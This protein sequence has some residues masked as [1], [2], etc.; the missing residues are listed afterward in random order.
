MYDSL[1]FGLWATVG[2]SG[3]LYVMKV[4]EHAIEK[5]LTEVSAHLR[6][7]DYISG[8]VGRF[9]SAQPHITQYVIA[10]QEDLS[11]EGVVTTL[12][13]AAV[14]RRSLIEATGRGPS[15][16]DY[17]ALDRAAKAVASLEALAEEEP[18]LASY[19]VSNLDLDT[20]RGNEVAGRVLAHVAKALVDA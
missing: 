12:F 15:T 3:T 14:L 1:V 10:H 4:P 2:S 9:R 19:A 7:D 6:E 13:H 17:L 18:H 8:E 20:P 16:V 5:V 11:V